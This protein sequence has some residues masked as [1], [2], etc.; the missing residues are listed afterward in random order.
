MDFFCNKQTYQVVELV[1]YNSKGKQLLDDRKTYPE[2][3]IIP[4][5]IIDGI[6][7]TACYNF[8]N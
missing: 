4:E 5:S 6:V 8:K 3:N 2:I 1:A 7:Q